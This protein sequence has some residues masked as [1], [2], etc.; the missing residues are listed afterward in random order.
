MKRS[1]LL[2]I[3]LLGTISQ[4]FAQKEIHFASLER[5]W[6]LKA[7]DSQFII[8]GKDGASRDT[9]RI[10]KAPSDRYYR[11]EDENSKGMIEG[12][13]KLD[14]DEVKLRFDGPFRNLDPIH[15]LINYTAAS[16][17]DSI[18]LVPENPEPIE[19]QEELGGQAPRGSS[20]KGNSYRWMW[21]I[22]CFVAGTV[23]GLLISRRKRIEPQAAN[24]NA[25]EEV[26]DFETEI[27]PV[28]N[29]P[30]KITQAAKDKIAKLEQSKKELN[31]ELRKLK[32]EYKALEEQYRIQAK[33]YREYFT[34][35]MKE[36]IIPTNDALEQGNRAEAAEGLVKLA[37][38]FT[39]IARHELGMKQTYDSVNIETLMRQ[40]V[41]PQDVVNQAD[42]KTPPDQLP[43]NIRNV[44][45][46]LQ[47]N[48]GGDTGTT[49]IFGY[50]LKR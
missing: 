39:S 20:E 6:I 31:A 21:F 25:P 10:Y 11:L 46:F 17:E 32:S 7:N 45:A 50:R 13:V 3:I 27:A 49:V 48:G 14:K 30:G 1:L 47:H 41:S 9:F 28:K 16:N 22:V 29:N 34:Q 5:A 4:I 44:R 24:V 23:L 42:S 33:F 18:I 35:V 37:A 12:I 38:H 36:V 19:A 26:R 40:N 15:Q 43:A 8:L 2:I